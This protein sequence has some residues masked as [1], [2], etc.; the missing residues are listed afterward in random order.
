MF[1]FRI[2]LGFRYDDAR[3]VEDRMNAFGYD[4]Q[5]LRRA[6]RSLIASHGPYAVHVAMKRARS[7]DDDAKEASAT[8]ARIASTIGELQGHVR[9]SA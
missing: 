8:W 9:P 7:M 2:S 3:P 6:A 4:Q 5:D 1:A